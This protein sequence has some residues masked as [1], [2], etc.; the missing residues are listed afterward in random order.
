MVAQWLRC[1]AT[2]RKV[3]GSIPAGVTGTF[4]WY[5][6]LPIALWPRGRLS[7]L[8]KWIPGALPGGK[9]GRWVRLTTLPPSCAVVTKSG[10]L[11]FLEPSGPL[12]ACNGTTGS[13]VSLTPWPEK[14]PKFTGRHTPS[15]RWDMTPQAPSHTSPRY[16]PQ[17]QEP[18][19]GV[20]NTSKHFNGRFWRRSLKIT[21]P[22]SSCL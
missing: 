3:A 19:R 20:I 9:G 13:V 18:P 16:D 21:I 11:N 7:L 10:N 1:S 6:I 14:G 12:Q 4:H 22:G 15:G 8:Q 5:K 2:K 17:A